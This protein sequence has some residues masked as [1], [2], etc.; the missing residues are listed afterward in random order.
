MA[1]LAQ[2]ER[3]ERLLAATLPAGVEGPPL[4]DDEA[5]QIVRRAW[6]RQWFAARPLPPPLDRMAP[7]AV[8]VLRRPWP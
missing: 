6:Q 2:L 5:R 4:S 1:D 8:E 3:L 7:D